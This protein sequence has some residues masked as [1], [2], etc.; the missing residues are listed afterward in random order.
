MTALHW[1]VRADDV[2]AV[3]LLIGAH[4]QVGAS[5]RYGIT[6]LYLAAKNG[7]PAVVEL[8]LAAGADANATLPEGETVLMTAA[9]TGN[10]AVIRA[11]VAHGAQVN[12]KESWQGQT[13]LMWAAS[14]NN[15]AAVRTLI[16]LGADKNDRSKLLSFP[17]FKW[18]TSG[19][20]VTVLPRG[21]WT[22]LMYA[23]RDGAIDATAALADARADL[24]AADPDGTTALMLAIINAHFDT[25]A[26]LVDRGADPNLT[27]STGMA[28]LYAAVDMHTLGPMLSRPAP[29]LV[30]KLD[31]S[32]LVRMLLAHGA[33]PNAR[34]R[35]PIIG[36]HH[37]PT[38]D[39]S[40]G[41][42]ATPLARAAK[43]NDLAV[44]RM[45]L[46]AGADPTLTLRDR[47][48]VAMIAAAGGAV[49]GAYAGAIPVTEESSLEAIKLCLDHGVDVNAFN[50]NGQTA[51]HN[52]VTRGT[53]TIVR[54]LADRG[55]K[56]DLR[57]KQGHTPLDI[58]QGAPGGPRR[59]VVN[60]RE[61]V[62]GLPN[63]PMIALIKEL[64]AK[65]G[66]ATPGQQ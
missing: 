45:L 28:A 48:T 37:T 42:G 23:A 27:D 7:D 43:S 15:A 51:L 34:L 11:L 2:A 6:P 61:V 19:M 55:A 56:L 31:A 54:Y 52:A 49:V 66:V 18:E 39:A 60:A 44:M 47:T 13:P 62:T 58:A 10:P 1:A 4:A 32:G 64:L 65:N 57:D 26:V 41:E 12:A 3:Q 17:E 21:S 20:V 53:L 59:R 29:K 38:G 40:L 30:D 9:R 46:D 8:L 14:Q 35:R 33:N 5:N 50:S 36:R 22:P 25:A 16:E 24:N 63:E